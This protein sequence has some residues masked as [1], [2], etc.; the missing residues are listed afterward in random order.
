[1]ITHPVALAIAVF[2]GLTAV[3]R[4]K[5]EIEARMTPRDYFLIILGAAIA[6]AVAVW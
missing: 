6:S 2:L 5:P 3:C 4:T 1:M